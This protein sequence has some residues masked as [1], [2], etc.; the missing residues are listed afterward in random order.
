MAI[1]SD[2]L[3]VMKFLGRQPR[4]M[5][6]LYVILFVEA[7]VLITTAVV[8]HLTFARLDHVSYLTA[9][10]VALLVALPITI[11][12]QN[13]VLE[14]RDSKRMLKA[15]VKE[16]VVARDEAQRSNHF[17][18]QFLANLSHELRTPLNSIVGFSQLLTKQAFGP[19]GD[20][21][22]RGYV[23]D[24]LMGGEHMLDL[25]NDILALSKMESGMA[26]VEDVDETDVGDVILEAIHLLMPM[27][28][29]H[30]VSLGVTGAT[31]GISLLMSERML[32]QILLNILSNAV[33]FTESDGCV[34]VSLDHRPTG[35]LA[36]LVHDTGVGMTPEE[37]E[38]AL[39]PFGQVANRAT[40]AQPEQGTGLGLPLVKAMMGLHKGTMRIDSV[41]NDGTII[42]LL[43]PGNLVSV[44]PR[45]QRISA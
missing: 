7:F 12:V 1:R 5:A 22:Y 26:A 18:S 8:A 33:K 38:I 23:D 2:V 19:L 34:R 43:F 35:E 17:K 41:P 16:V 42:V 15:L 13:L 25:I 21:R 31:D 6:T 27:A 37:V 10:I 4:H 28:D 24:I 29:R 36:I 32:R 39:T 3:G 11:F 45:L 44:S 14:L 30:Q 9:G 20:A 40:E